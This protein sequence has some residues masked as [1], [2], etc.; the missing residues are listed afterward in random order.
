MSGTLTG[1]GWLSPSMRA[2]KEKSLSS[3]RSPKERHLGNLT[4][5]AAAA[6][7]GGGK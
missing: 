5:A 7:S 4:E 1:Q 6:V 2:S 3:N